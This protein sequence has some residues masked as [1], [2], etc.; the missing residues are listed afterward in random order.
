MIA[1][2]TGNARQDAVDLDDVQGNILRGYRKSRVRHLVVRVVDPGQAR[3]WVK[4]IVGSDRSLAPAIT[5]AGH[6]GAQP[7]DV[8]FNLGLTFTGLLALG[9]PPP[10][11][12]TFP[13]A[14]RDGMAARAVKLGDWGDS[15]PEY[16]QPWFRQASAVHGVVS[17]YANTVA[18]LDDYERAL[19]SG[20]GAR[21]VAVAGRN[22]GGVF[23]A[24]HHADAAR[25]RDEVHFGYRDS[26]SQPRFAHLHGVGK[27]D[28]QPRAPLGTVLLGHETAFEGVSWGLPNPPVLGVNGAFN[29]YRVL[30]QDV[31]AFEA[32]LDRA[33]NEV[34]ATAV[35][36]ELL[37][38]D[39][40]A[41]A[42]PARRF[43]AMRELVAAKLG[44]RWRNGT[45]LAL[46]PREPAP[47]PPVSDT[48]FDYRDDLDG[49][50]CP[51][52]S[53]IRR[54]N[55]RGGQIVQRIANHTRRLVRRG[56]PYGPK[57][58]P[59]APDR[60]ERGLLGNFL[61]ADLA[62]QFEAIQYDWINL[63]LQDPRVTGSNDPLLGAND[64]Q[65]SWFDLPTSQGPIRLRGLPRFVRTRGGAYTFFPGIS[66]LHWIGSLP[67]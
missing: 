16:W 1:R 65:T 2:S 48:A 56:L 42:D 66:A 41:S 49:L 64:P 57:F 26:I 8:C 58:D 30:E 32:F 12:Q 15:A 4:A 18:L 51:F 25:Q 14:F 44:G 61:C 33:A 46:S 54:S 62:A 19:M 13:E 36:H 17:L 23:N 40:A 38:F 10:A 60:A 5:R 50:K 34:L 35:A 53:H 52:G 63:G 45:P 20:L 31:A 28:D 7:P 29:A 67:R 39:L 59:S 22:D 37:P 43:E 27:Y 9:V 11:A 55:P 3:H 24:D 21:A 47:Q 6:W